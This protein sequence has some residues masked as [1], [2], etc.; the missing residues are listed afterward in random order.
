MAASKGTNSSPLTE[1]TA[2]LSLVEHALCP[3]DG[4]TSL[5]ENYR[6]ET[7]YRYADSDGFRQTAKVVVHS[8]A[9]LS[10]TDEFYLWGLMAL[11]FAQAEPRIEFQATP[12]FCL[13]R[14]GVISTDSKGGKNYRLFRE[15]LRR[16]SGVRYQNDRFYDPIRREHRQVSFGLL[17]YSLPMELESTR[18]WR[19]LW[20]PLFFEYVQAMAS[21]LSFDLETYRSLDPASRRL[22]L[23]LSK[24]FWRSAVSPHFELRHLAV[25]VLGFSPTLA[26]RTLKAKVARCAKVL[27]NH[28]V[29]PKSPGNANRTI[30]KQYK[31]QYRAQFMRGPHYDKSRDQKKN[32]RIE[33]SPL[34]DPLQAIGFDLASVRRILR[35]FSSKQIQLWADVTLAAMESKGPSF[36]R[37]SPQ[38]FFM[39]NIKNATEG[40]RTPPDWFWELRQQ[41]Q[42]Q[43]AERARQV[44]RRGKKQ[45]RERSS[46]RGTLSRPILDLS[47]D[48][49]ALA[50]ELF[51]HFLAAGQSEDD[52]RRNALQFA[53]E[54]LRGQRRGASK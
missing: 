33:D 47:K 34:L 54:S 40:R 19:I 17:S 21:Q 38:A 27:E 8:P 28:E 20:D 25:D 3:L 22:F 5:R 43:R 32:G 53:K 42:R 7:E 49:G 2:Q 46:A 37:R 36:F 16:L 1:G 50:D 6:Y 30:R 48:D 51:A 29:L 23:L 18:A 44:Q 15:S 41:E 24:V 39:D 35:R 12:H 45:D 11:T 10:A 52:A 9:G 26:T 31:G 13:R 4:R 14:L